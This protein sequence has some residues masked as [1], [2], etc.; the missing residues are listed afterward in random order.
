MIYALCI[1]HFNNLDTLSQTMKFVHILPGPTKCGESPLFKK[2]SVKYYMKKW[3]VVITEAVTIYPLDEDVEQ[4]LELLVIMNNRKI[5][6]HWNYFDP[7]YF[8]DSYPTEEQKIVYWNVQINFLWIEPY[9]MCNQP[10]LK[11]YIDVM[12]VDC[13]KR[14]DDYYVDFSIEL[15]G[16]VN[17]EMKEYCYIRGIYKKNDLIVSEES[18]NE[19]NKKE[20]EKCD[21]AELEGI[22]GF[23]DFF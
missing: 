17:K 1:Y 12:S 21:K 15:P 19:W 13:F 14:N 5:H 3:E 18:I 7:N 6:N 22:G 11:R 16:Q 2:Y 23:S 10:N 9:E 20:C 8:I 4:L